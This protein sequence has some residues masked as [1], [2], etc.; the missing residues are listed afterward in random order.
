ML[1]KINQAQKAKYFHVLSHCVV[2]RTAKKKKERKK[3]T[4]LSSDNVAEGR[5]W[6]STEIKLKNVNMKKIT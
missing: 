5:G 3:Q 4:S 1:S 2:R 6:H